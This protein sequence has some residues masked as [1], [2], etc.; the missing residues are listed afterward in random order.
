MPLLVPYSYCCTLRL[1]SCCIHFGQLLGTKPQHWEFKQPSCLLMIACSMC[2]SCS[3][4]RSI[5]SAQQLAQA[6]CTAVTTLHAA[7]LSWDPPGCICSCHDNMQNRSWQLTTFV[8]SGV[9]TLFTQ[10][11]GL[12]PWIRPYLQTLSMPYCVYLLAHSSAGHLCFLYLSSSHLVHSTWCAAAIQLCTH[13]IR[14]C[15]AG[16]RCSVAS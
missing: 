1:Q 14:A 15:H 4:S 13:L 9:E 2:T 8:N 10:C 12:N 11:G 16:W 7:K 5:S 3:M 6:R